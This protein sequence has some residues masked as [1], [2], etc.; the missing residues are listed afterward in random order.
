MVN[1]TLP[2][3]LHLHENYFYMTSTITNENKQNFP[4]FSV[5]IPTYKDWESLKICLDCLDDQTLSKEKFEI[6]VV[7]NNVAPPPPLRLSKNVHLCSESKPGSYAARNTGLSIATGKFLAFTDSDCRPVPNWLESAHDYFENHPDIDFFGGI[8]KLSF[9]CAKPNIWEI[10]EKAYAFQQHEILNG[11]PYSVT[12]NMFAH[13]QSFKKVG[14]FDDSLLSGGD[15]DW[16]ARATELGLKIGYAPSVMV[17]H[18]ARNSFKEVV[19]KKLRTAGG[20][21]NSKRSPIAKLS[22]VIAGIF[23]PVIPILKVSKRHDL[24][25]SEKL[26]AAILEYGLRLS[27]SFLFLMFFSKIKKPNNR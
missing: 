14:L 7:N 20:L 18:P 11:R 8:I 27:R 26:K 16:G 10:Y 6:I 15:V 3:H 13:K 19:T 9:S 22:V 17:I 21:Y 25:V 1:E 4:L 5:I 2:L 23:P 24:T 12:A